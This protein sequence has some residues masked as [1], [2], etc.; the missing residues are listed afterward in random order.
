MAAVGVNCE[1]R[2]CGGELS[3][4]GGDVWLQVGECLRAGVCDL[5][6]KGSDEIT[7]ITYDAMPRWTGQVTLQNLQFGYRLVIKTVPERK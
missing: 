6:L 3:L 7:N 4:Q 5:L 2:D 1:R